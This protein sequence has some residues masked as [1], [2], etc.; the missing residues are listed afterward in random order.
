MINKTQTQLARIASSAALGAMSTMGAVFAQSGAYLPSDDLVIV[1]ME[2]LAEAAGWT[3]SSDL[4]GFAGRGYVEWS[5]PDMAKQPGTGLVGFETRLEAAGS[6]E[7][8][9]HNRHD[10]PDV[11]DANDVWLRVDGGAW[12]KVFSSVRG[13]WTWDTRQRSTAGN[14]GPVVLELEAG[15]HK[16]ELS[17]RS[18]GF[19]V[20]RVHLFKQGA[21]N[22]LSISHAVSSRVPTE[23]VIQPE[24]EA[25]Q[26]LEAP[27]LEAM[28]ETAGTSSDR[29]DT[30][31]VQ[32][33]VPE[34]RSSETEPSA[35]VPA[36]EAPFAFAAGG[37]SGK[38]LP[39]NLIQPRPIILSADQALIARKIRDRANSADDARGGGQPGPKVRVNEG[40]DAYI[41][42]S[43]ERGL[44]L[45]DIELALEGS[46]E[47]PGTAFSQGPFVA[48]NY[49][50]NTVDQNKGLRIRA[51]R[52]NREPRVVQP[53]I[54]DI[55]QWP[56]GAISY[57]DT[58]CIVPH[59]SK[60]WAFNVHL[61]SGPV[62]QRESSLTWNNISVR[63]DPGPGS[64]SLL[65]GTREYNV[66]DRHF[67][68]CDFTEIPRAHGT[69][70]SS[71]GDTTLDGCTFL[72]IGGQGAQFS[73]RADPNG[74]NG[75]NN[76]A[77]I[78]RPTHTVRDCHFID[79]GWFAGWASFSLTY[80]TPGTSEFPGSLLVEDSSFV[81]KFST[82]RSDGHESSGALLAYKDRNLESLD[83]E[84]GQMMTNVT[85]RNCLFD[86]TNGDRAI[87]DLKS[88]DELRIE[89]CCFI[90]RN[91]DYPYVW[92]DLDWSG[93][94]LGGTKTQRIVLRDNVSD[95]V[96]LRIHVSG[97]FGHTAEV[98]TISLHCP[99]EEVV[100]DGVT[101]QEIS[102]EAL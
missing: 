18:Q 27:P 71:N 102:R 44:S 2:D 98:E 86:Y 84:L 101:G 14:V 4:A 82:P 88:M 36:K 19:K 72:R 34:A 69:Y 11:T 92:V 65:F 99:G 100:Y 80:A 46:S 79:N 42:T 16:I 54:S 68:N 94:D 15:N 25:P 49:L 60:Q 70:V 89:E 40:L 59:S 31:E 20:D 57:S 55:T 45:E 90:A 87:A 41:E 1:E 17:G 48:K 30:V 66:P 91:H 61:G 85:I 73:H 3:S 38:T 74:H 29:L 50:E 51:L 75:Q 47:G 43:L 52:M 37:K 76:F 77:Y 53:E 62:L 64:S 26:R 56:G 6:Y 93:D 28:G 35:S 8:R 13:D 5:G 24:V 58:L 12:T 95:G 78:D 96:S 83:P 97:P 39:V 9:L 81:S 23:P 22:A 10:A 63:P 33:E 32:R 7:L 21:S 67:F